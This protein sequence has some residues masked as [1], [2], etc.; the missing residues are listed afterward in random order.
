MIDTNIDVAGLPTQHI[1]RINPA[2][3]STLVQDITTLFTRLEWLV[4][5]ATHMDAPRPFNTE[6]EGAFLVCSSWLIFHVVYSN[7]AYILF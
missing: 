2:M 1:N 3:H 4:L 6:A 7:Y 5:A